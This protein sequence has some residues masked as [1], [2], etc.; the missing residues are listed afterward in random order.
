MAEDALDL[1]CLGRSSVDL[2]R[3]QFGGPL[4]TMRRQGG[5]KANWLELGRGGT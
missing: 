1:V 4:E 3:E 2:Y 5:V